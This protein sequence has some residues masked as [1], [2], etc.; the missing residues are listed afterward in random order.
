MVKKLKHSASSPECRGCIWQSS[1]AV[2]E[3]RQSG[4]SLL[5]H[6]NN[7]QQGGVVRGRGYTE[8]QEAWRST[9][10]CQPP[11]QLIDHHHM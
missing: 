3:R 7:V 11:L 9:G 5:L 4:A 10:S 2:I 6:S 8:G 1:P